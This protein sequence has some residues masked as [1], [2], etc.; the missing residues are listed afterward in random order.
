MIECCDLIL[1][2]E[3]DHQ[4]ITV[5]GIDLFMAKKTDADGCVVDGKEGNIMYTVDKVR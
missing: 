1:A 3:D 4:P 2:R 5:H